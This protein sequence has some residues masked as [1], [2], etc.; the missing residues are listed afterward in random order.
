M[1]KKIEALIAQIKADFEDLVQ[2]DVDS[3]QK[4]YIK[5]LEDLLEDAE[6]LKKILQDQAGRI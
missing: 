6:I 2:D 4:G 5:T 3:V 1:R